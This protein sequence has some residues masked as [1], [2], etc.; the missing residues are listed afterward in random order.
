MTVK[1]PETRLMIESRVG[2]IYTAKGENGYSPI[3]AVEFS[4][5]TA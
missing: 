5:E 3:Y 1:E 4:K 2:R